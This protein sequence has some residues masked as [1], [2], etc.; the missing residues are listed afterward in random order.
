MQD[1]TPLPIFDNL[2]QLLLTKSPVILADFHWI[3]G[4]FCFF[5]LKMKTK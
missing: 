2:P 3:F 4:D 5:L 1:K